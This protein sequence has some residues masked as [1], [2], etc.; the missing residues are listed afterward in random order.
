MNAVARI[1]SP[2]EAT[3]AT[4]FDVLAWEMELAAARAILLDSVIGEM[5]KCLSE[6]HRA[7]F[8]EHLHAVDL[9]AQQ[10]TSLSAFTRR[11]SQA[12]P[13]DVSAS[14]DRA[15]GDITLGAL[16]DRMSTAFG[17]EER[18][19]NDHEDAGEADFF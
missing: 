7:A 1:Q 15:L 13:P 19:V 6:S 2:L 5:T 9:L 3:V 8:V 17:G 12:V 11:M 16:A 18:G 14:V 4:T 10:L